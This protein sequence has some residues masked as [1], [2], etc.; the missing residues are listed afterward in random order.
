MKLAPKSIE[1]FVKKPSP[2]ALV[3]LVYGPDEGLVRER[4]DILTK[5]VVP[6]IHDP[7][8][9]VEFS[10]DQLAENP[11]RLLDEAQSISMLGGRRVVRV[12]DASDKITKTVED[13]LPLLKS[14]D[15][16]ILLEGGELP[17]R[18]TLRALLER[19]ENGAA[20]PCYVEDARDISRVIGDAMR[21]AGYTIPSDAITYMAG[22][23]TGDRAVA[24]SEV[25][26]LITYM[27]AGKKAVALDD[28]IACVGNSAALSLDD[29]AKHVAS[30]NFAE[31]D[32]ILDYVLSEGAPAVS[33]LRAL[34]S[35][36][37]RLHITKTRIQKGEGMDEAMKKL[38]PAVFFKVKDAF[39]SQLTGW[40]LGQMEQALAHL[41]SVEA[42]CKQTGSNPET[43]CSRAILSLSQIGLKATGARRRA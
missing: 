30:G 5:N 12:R 36:F 40:S 23:V 16:L 3:I 24:R 7:F 15:N 34:Q 28:V 41:S 21:E 11:A 37:L 25:E 29:L 32:R 43:L 8:N 35:H 1:G 6:D 39:I 42:K 27:G 9:V 18:S 19:V 10:A 14:G 13:A 20:V 38:R 22:N 33:V 26:K 4:L 2:S 31:A 17:P